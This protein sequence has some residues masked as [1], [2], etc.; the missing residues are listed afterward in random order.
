MAIII[1]SVIA[2]FMFV[3]SIMY[4]LDFRKERKQIRKYTTDLYQP[5]EQRRSFIVLLGDRFDKTDLAKPMNE[6]LKSANIPLT[7]S[8]FIAAQ[9]VTFMGLVLIL[10]NMFQVNFTLSLLLSLIILGVSKRV[11]F[12]LRKNKMKERFAEQLPEIC[13]VLANSTRSGLTLN[14]S[15]HVVAQ[16]VNEPARDEFK[17]LAHELSL[18]VEFNKAIESMEERIDNREFKLFTATIQIQKKAG[19]NLS[20]ILDEM[21]QTLENRK[22]LQQEIKTMTAEQ[23]YIAYL[24]PVIPIFLVLMM[25]NIVDG[26]LDPLFTWIGI[27]LLVIFIAG[28]GLTAFL[29][30]RIT[31]I[32]V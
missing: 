7:P 15:I 28:I 29:V 9:I 6:K 13:R 11:L 24:V 8:E 26:F 23:K 20:T 2:T 16:E 18:G 30:R 1:L 31:N 19:G 22:V 4:Y 17:R 14:Q 32:R 3:I 27:V 25:N 21:G 12:L 5:D 10:S